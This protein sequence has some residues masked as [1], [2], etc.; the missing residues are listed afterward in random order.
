MLEQVE[1]FMLDLLELV[2]L[3]V[4]IFD[5]EKVARLGV[6]VNEDAAAVA[7]KLGFDFEDALAFEHRAQDVKG[8]G[9]FGIVGLNE[10]AEKGLCGFLLDG[11]GRSGGR[12]GVDA[13]PI[14][15]E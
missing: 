8:G 3:K 14:R 4:W 2:E 15:D 10:F 12:D 6:L 13:L 9:E 1:D 5:L 11:L 7:G